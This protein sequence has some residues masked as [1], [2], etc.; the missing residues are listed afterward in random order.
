ME[1]PK[2][3]M[4]SSGG[5]V[6]VIVWGVGRGFGGGNVGDE[7]LITWGARGLR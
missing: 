3:R 5:A 1:A 7:M 2:Q 6:W 4:R